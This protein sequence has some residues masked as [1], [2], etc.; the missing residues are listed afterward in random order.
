MFPLF[1]KSFGNH[2]LDHRSLYY[3]D[4]TAY[5][6]NQSSF[7]D[8][9]WIFLW[10]LSLSV[11][12]VIVFLRMSPSL[13]MTVYLNLI[14]IIKINYHYSINSY[15]FSINIL[16]LLVPKI[17]PIILNLLLPLHFQSNLV[18]L[19]FYSNPNPLN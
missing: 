2:L 3:Y 6:F 9:L 11:S 7:N 8:Y 19:I 1:I 16:F 4:F 18:V 17:L 5:S 15:L 14:Q 12:T 13:N 10:I